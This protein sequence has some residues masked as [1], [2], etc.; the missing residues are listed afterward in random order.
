MDGYK[1][2]CITEI[3]EGYTYNYFLSASAS[4]LIG[5]T[6]SVIYLLGNSTLIWAV[7]GVL[8]FTLGII[9]LLIKSGTVIDENEKRI[10]RYDSLFNKKK[11]VWNSLKNCTLVTIST[12]SISQTLAL[13]AQSQ[14]INAKLYQLKLDYPTKKGVFYHE[15]SDYNTVVMVANA[16][17]KKIKIQVKNQVR[18]AQI[19]G[20]KNRKNRVRR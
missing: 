18:E 15:F 17:Q 7:L 13:G 1:K 9:L 16:I 3:D 5:G 14:S 12:S 11:I 4:I 10:G 8:I 20:V 19:Q 2:D 6:I